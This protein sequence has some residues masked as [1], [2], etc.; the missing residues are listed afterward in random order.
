MC[1]PPPQALGCRLKDSLL[2]MTVL[3]LLA[4]NE[5]DVF[6]F[7]ERIMALK[8]KAFVLRLDKRE[9]SGNAGQHSPHATPDDLLESLDERQFFLVECGIF[10]YGV[11]VLWRVRF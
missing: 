2:N 5:A 6:V 1:V 9:A 8:N 11:D 3:I 10:G 4:D 7:L